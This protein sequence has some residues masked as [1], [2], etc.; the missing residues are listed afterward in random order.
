M[1]VLDTNVVSE[2]LKAA[3]E[4]AV[5]AWLD[6]QD[7][8]TLFLSTISLAE[9]RYGVAALPDGKRKEGLG[10]ALENRVVALFDQRLLSFDVAA[11]RA[12]AII[13]ARAKAVGYTLGAADGYIAATA[14]AHDF[15][16]ATR[17]IDPFRSAGVPI[18]DPWKA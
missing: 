8:E 14:A 6:R 2:A 3:P 15:A 7:I 18:I 5:L 4:P 1:I 16:V 10:A 12:Y 17:D 11:T 13:R 9:L